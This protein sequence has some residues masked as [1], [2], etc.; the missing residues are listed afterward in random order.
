MKSWRLLILLLVILSLAILILS[1]WMGWFAWDIF[2]VFHKGFEHRPY[3][4]LQPDLPPALA[5][6]NTLFTL[7][8]IGVLTLFLIPKPIS[9]MKTALLVPPLHLLRLFFLGLVSALLVIA[10]GI[11]AALTMSTFPII[12]LLG[13]LLFLSGFTGITAIAFTIGSELFKRAGWSN[14][15]PLLAFLLGI[16]ILFPLTKVP[17]FGIVIGFFVICLGIGTAIVTRFGTGQTWNLSPLIDD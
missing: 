16:V 9:K 8:L 2:G 1:S 3:H 5:G 17:Y 7:Y 6:I 11:S 15:S 4:A 12:I 13:F 14:Q 10:I